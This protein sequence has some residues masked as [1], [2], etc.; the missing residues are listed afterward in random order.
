MYLSNN[1]YDNAQRVAIENRQKLYHTAAA[2]KVG[3]TC[4]CPSCVKDFVKKSYQ[5]KFCS[6]KGG[7]NC[8]DTYW[9]TVDPKRAGR[10][11]IL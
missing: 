11:F 7:G 2:A 5:Q 6:N 8:K 1:H 3:Q 10:G 9:N 4:K